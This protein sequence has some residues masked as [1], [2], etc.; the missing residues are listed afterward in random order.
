MIII[1]Y[2]HVH[3]RRWTIALSSFGISIILTSWNKLWNIPSF[4]VFQKSLYRIYNISV[5]SFLTFCLKDFFFVRR[6]LI[7]NSIYERYGSMQIF[8]LLP[9]LIYCISKEFVCFPC[10]AEVMPFLSV[11]LLVV[12]LSLFVILI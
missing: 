8:F 6:I 9:V 3:E 7:T 11:A 12:C 2:L 10:I 5:I 4:S 1:Y